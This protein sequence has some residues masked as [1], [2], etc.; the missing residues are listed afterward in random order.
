MRIEHNN[1]DHKKGE[2]LHLLLSI[3]VTAPVFHFDTSE[4]N[5]DASSNTAREGATKKERKKE[6]KK[7]EKKTERVRTK[8]QKG[9]EITLTL[10][11]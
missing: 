5:A 10:K 11:H 1:G 4:L 8:Q 2:R 6:R 9:R 7:E 3:F